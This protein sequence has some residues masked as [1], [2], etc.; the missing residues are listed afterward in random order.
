MKRKDKFLLLIAHMGWVLG[1]VFVVLADFAF[2]TRDNYATAAIIF[3]CII[4][5]FYLGM[6]YCV[7]RFMIKPNLWAFQGYLDWLDGVDK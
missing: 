3:C 4:T 2:L 7:Y 5:G 6:S 1:L